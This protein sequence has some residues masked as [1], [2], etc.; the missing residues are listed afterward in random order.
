MDTVTKEMFDL[1][2]EYHVPHKKSGVVRNEAAKQALSI[3]HERLKDVKPK[4][5]YTINGNRLF[6]MHF[7]MVL[8]K[9]LI[10]NNYEVACNELGSLIYRYPISEQRIRAIVLH[11]L[12]RYL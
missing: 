6:Y 10:E 4:E 2:G 1:I 9:A 11:T 12:E 3:F 7:L 5:W 8:R